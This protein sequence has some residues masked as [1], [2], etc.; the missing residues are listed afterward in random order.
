MVMSLRNLFAGIVAEC[1]GSH[2][3]NPVRVASTSFGCGILGFGVTVAVGALCGLPGLVC[4]VM[5]NPLLSKSP[6]S[7]K[8][9]SSSDDELDESDG[10]RL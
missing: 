10:G 9:T 4:P 7:E 8:Y 1:D 2:L 6:S 5:T 3:A